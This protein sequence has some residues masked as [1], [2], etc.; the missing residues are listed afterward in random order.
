MAT[1]RGEPVD[2]PAVSFYEI[3]GFDINPSDPDEA[4]V[5][6]DPSWQPLLRLAEDETDLVRMRAPLLRP[7]PANC[8]DRFF[9]DQAYSEQGCRFVR[10]TLRVAGRT[11]TALSKRDPALDTVW[12]VEHLLKDVDDLNAYLELPDE[13]FAYRPDVGNLVAADREVGD[14]GIVMVDAEDPL[15]GAASLF[16]METFTMIAFFEEGLFGCL[17]DKLAPHYHERTRQVARSFPGHLWRIYGP[18]FATEPYLS[19]RHFESY[20]VCRTGPMAEAIRASGGFARIH[21]HG[22]IKSILPHIVRMGAAAIDPIEPPPLGNVELADVRREY[23]KDLVLF[24][25]LELRDIENMEPRD[26]EKVVA[27]ALRDG[28][29]GQGRGFVLRPSASPCGR[30]ITA[31]TLANYRTI[32]R[33]A[34]GF[35]L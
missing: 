28:T 27:K 7:A 32:V 30:T 20:V 34:A 5:Y 16:S 15:C 29:R 35:R 24:G 18:E 22:R 31:R 14:R 26:F 17:L 9:E 23:G 6:S 21:S 19:E 4:N 11:M 8:R 25:N 33:L 13:V 3:G 10:T 1:L 2:R 12:Q